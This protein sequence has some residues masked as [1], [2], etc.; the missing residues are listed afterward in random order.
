VRL[1]NWLLRSLAT[2]SPVS[3]QRE[4]RGSTRTPDRYDTVFVGSLSAQTD[5][6]ELQA[7][8]S[9]CIG[10][11]SHAAVVTNGGGVSKG[12][13]FVSFQNSKLAARAVR[14]GLGEQLHGQHVAVRPS[15]EGRWRGRAD[16]DRTH[17]KTVVAS[18]T[19][20]P[21]PQHVS[22]PLHADAS[23]GLCVLQAMHAVGVSPNRQTFHNILE[24]CAAVAKS[25][26]QRADRSPT[27]PIGPNCGRKNVV[28]SVERASQEV[29]AVSMA[30][31]NRHMAAESL[32]PDEETVALQ[33]RVCA[34]C[35]PPALSAAIALVD[36]NELQ[37][38]GVT[39]TTKLLNGLL[40]V[41]SRAGDVATAFEIF[42]TRY[43]KR[44]TSGKPDVDRNLDDFDGDV[45][46]DLHGNSAD[47]KSVRPLPSRGTYN[48]LISACARAVKNPSSPDSGPTSAALLQLA[49]DAYKQM[50][51]EGISPDHIT[52]TS[53]LHV[54]AKH[55]PTN[56]LRLVPGKDEAD[57]ERRHTERVIALFEASVSD[58]TQKREKAALARAGLHAASTPAVE[59]NVAVFSALIGA[60][61]PNHLPLEVAFILGQAEKSDVILN[62]FV[63]LNLAKRLDKV[64]V[65]PSQFSLETRAEVVD[66]ARCALRYAERH[67]VASQQ[68]GRAVVQQLKRLINSTTHQPDAS[69]ASIL[70]DGTKRTGASL[71]NE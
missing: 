21:L 68:K 1:F 43:A 50:V 59:P 40:A 62:S 47:I 57:E 44:S 14:H 30:F 2:S 3:Q 51:E 52:L 49:F 46:G 71:K 36:P 32:V 24:L 61:A 67:G 38:K 33:L 37:R 10:P 41:Y 23:T 16:Q 11:V 45:G 8:F 66:A 64:R 25:S 18:S 48:I 56:A 69:P 54:C 35:T 6:A 63:L 53:L 27:A 28:A 4:R 15:K 7:A 42:S 13:G 20:V 65:D 19:A 26:I 58:V 39:P 70:Q 55:A 22:M 29:L 34:S 9:R 12:Y 17:E 5:A 60:I 31:V